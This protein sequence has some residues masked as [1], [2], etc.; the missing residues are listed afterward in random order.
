MA[1][2]GKRAH[3]CLLDRLPGTQ[4]QPFYQ[5][6]E[7]ILTQH[8]FDQFV[9][10][11][12]RK[13][14]A[15]R[16]GRPSIAPGVYFRAL[17]MGYLEGLSS[18]RAIAW[19]V[20]DS[21]SLRAWLGFGPTQKVPAHSTLSRTRKRLS[22]KV[23]REV[24]RFVLAR[25]GEQGLLCGQTLGVDASTIEANAALRNIVRRDN[26]HSYEQFL[27]ELLKAA[28][29]QEPTA[30]Q[31]R[32]MDKKRKKK[33]SNK[34]WK[35]PHEPSARIIKLKNGRT[36]FG[37]KDEHAVDLGHRSRGGGAGTARGPWRLPKP[38]PDS[39]GGAGQPVEHPGGRRGAG[40][41]QSGKRGGRRQGLPQH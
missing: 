13:F 32:R 12:C 3:P 8:G 22:V 21:L 15:R 1:M 30:E 16:M 7:E 28:G 24:F 40:P 38:A 20:Q 27:D 39:E 6:L 26:G 35:S 11:L 36:H 34:E 19:R 2:G 14:Y 4:G 9:E 33:M 41:K 37:Y 5:K 31:R 17:L 29:V 23:H 18:E 10:P 25:L